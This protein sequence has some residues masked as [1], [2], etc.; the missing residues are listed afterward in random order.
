MLRVDLTR[1]EL[2]ALKQ[3]ALEQ[4]TTVQKLAGSILRERLA[5]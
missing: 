3:L 1:A 4:D 2:K 5:A